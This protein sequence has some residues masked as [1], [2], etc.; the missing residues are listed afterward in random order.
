MLSY[1]FALDHVYLSSIILVFVLSA[2]F[3]LGSL[4]SLPPPSLHFNMRLISVLCR[5]DGLHR[6]VGLFRLHTFH[7]IDN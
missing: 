5:V 6:A 3:P 1:A 7:H 4:S 2:K